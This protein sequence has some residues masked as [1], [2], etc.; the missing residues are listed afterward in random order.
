MQD[1]GAMN[2]HPMSDRARVAGR[3]PL[4]QDCHG[5]AGIV[6]R[7]ADAPRTPA[8]DGLLAAAAACVWRAGPVAKGAGLCHGTAG[9]AVALL[10]QAQRSGQPLWRERAQAFA[11]HAVAQVDAA[12]AQHGRSR[13]SLWTGDAGVACLL[14]QCLQG[15][16]ACPTLDLF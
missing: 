15:G 9:N 11:M 14:W 4:V 16:S 8:W 12:H 1:G 6:V 7:L 13:A 3:V 5:A 2:W 10:K